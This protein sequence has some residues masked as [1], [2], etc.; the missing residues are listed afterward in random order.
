MADPL[1][2]AAGIVGILGAAT[3]VSIGLYH[4][5]HAF[6]DAP[7]QA[8]AVLTEVNETRGILLQLQDFTSGRTFAAASRTSM[9][10]VEHIITVI[11]G[12]IF[13]FSNLEKTH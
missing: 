7:L 12:A 13:T 10:K 5:V 3:R 2:I 1:S 11:S 9:L 8:R 4:F 6:K